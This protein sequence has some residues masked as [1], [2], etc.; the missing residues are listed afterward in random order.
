M[1]AEHSRLVTVLVQPASWRRRSAW[2]FLA[3]SGGVCGVTGGMSRS[4]AR[5]SAYSRARPEG[6]YMTLV[7]SCCGGGDRPHTT[8]T[9]GFYT[10]VRSSGAVALLA[11]SVP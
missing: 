6:G 11:V 8:R 1:T 10:R 9:R 7:S 5:D 2:M 3:T 4:D